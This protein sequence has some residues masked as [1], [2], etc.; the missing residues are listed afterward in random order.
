MPSFFRGYGK[1]IMLVSGRG[2]SA[3][4]NMNMF[5]KPKSWRWGWKM[6]DFFHLMIKV[7]GDL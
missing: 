5:L 3:W 4:K 6:G 1:V 7:F 2:I